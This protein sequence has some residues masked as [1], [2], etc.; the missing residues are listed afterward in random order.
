MAQSCQHEA[1]IQPVTPASPDT[2]PSCV[3]LGDKWMHLRICLVC[4]HVG[5]CDQSRNRHATRHYHRTGHPVMQS[6]EVGEAWRWC[7]IDERELPPGEP[8]RQAVAAP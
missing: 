2:C 8:Y 4:G 3:A 1:Q 7:Y 5:C 6:Y